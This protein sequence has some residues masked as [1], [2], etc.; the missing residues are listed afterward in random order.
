MAEE[1]FNVWCLRHA[2][3]FGIAN[4]NGLAMIASWEDLFAA[5]GYSAADLNDATDWLAT[6]APPKFLNEHLGA[7]TNRI[8]DRK[9]VDGRRES[10]E[11][12]DRGSCTTCGGTG[13]VTVPH[14]GGVVDGEWV[15]QRFARGGA[16]Y[17]TVA[18]YCRCALG[19]WFEGRHDN[20]EKTWNLDRY[21]PRNPRWRVHMESRRSERNARAS[22]GPVD[23]GWTDLV[24]H[25]LRQA[26]VDTGE[27]IP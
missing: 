7:I 6:H 5:A 14:P 20:D 11:V 9:A 27:E 2:N 12:H 4:A 8:R 10:L 23:D 3:V 22:L 17:Y 24:D 21:E 18:V 13:H 15:P 16:T 25:L 26:G 19:R 1:W